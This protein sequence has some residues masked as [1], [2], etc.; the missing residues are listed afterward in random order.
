MGEGYGL[1]LFD[2]LLFD[3]NRPDRAGGAKLP[4]VVPGGAESQLHGIED[5]CSDDHLW[6]VGAV[7]E[8]VKETGDLAFLDEAIPF[9][10]GD[11]ASVY[12]HLRRA[13]E[14]TDRH[15]GAHGLAQGLRADWN[16]CLN[17]GG[18]E[19]AFTTFLHVWAARQLAEVAGV[20]G[21]AADV[22]RYQAM[23][24]RVAA[25]AE[26]ELWDGDWYVRGITAG[27]VRL[28]SATSPEG[29]IFLEH[30]GW[31]VLAGVASPERGRRALDAVH[32][33]LAS[34]HGLHLCAPSYT[35]IDDTIGY[36]TRVYPGVKENGAIFSHPNAWPMIAEAVLGRG[37]RAMEYYEALAPANDND[38]AERRRAEPYVYAQFLYG[39]DHP[40]YGRAENPWL[41]GTAGWVYQAATKYILGVRPGFGGLTVDPC[42]PAAW[43][44][45]TMARRWRGAR[46]RIEVVNGAAG[47]GVAAAV[48]DGTPLELVQDGLTGRMSARLPWTEGDHA[49][50][51]ELA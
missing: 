27:G 3:E 47:S 43:P 30:M 51:V 29:R 18:G 38:A 34:P 10:D 22:T 40:L 28:G 31:A 1:H 4:T 11:V 37:E 20:L 19:S 45:F 13:V 36:V 21:R 17:L 50:R 5:A 42:I 6:L 12:E 35:V 44:G 49:V 14:F 48:A 33:R 41:T 15:A 2:P 16:D 26:R 9:A 46:Y 39:R 7:A 23:A 24:D 25:V 32:E 8:Y